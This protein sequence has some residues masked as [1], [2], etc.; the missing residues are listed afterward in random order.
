[1]GGPGQQRDRV[2]VTRALPG[3][4]LAATLALAGCTLSS[5]ATGNPSAL[6]DQASAGTQDP[7]NGQDESPRR[8]SSPALE[9]LDRLPV[10]SRAGSAG[11]YRRSE[12]GQSWVDTDGNGCNQRDDVLLRDA[13]PDRELVV[14]T[15]G[16][17]DHDVLAGTWLDPYT[18][19]ELTFT[20]LKDQAQ[21]QAIQIDHVVSLSDAWASGAW[22]WTPLERIGFANDL[23]NL[24]AV[25][26][27]TNQAKS[28]RGPPDWLPEVDRCRYVEHYVQVK[29]AY[30]LGVSGDAIAGLRRLL[31]QCA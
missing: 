2:R 3:L 12:F 21:A 14:V 20:D 19:R 9:A 5:S 1:M 28:D 18:G 24:L 23:D 27:P 22:E 30:G 10:I 29:D 16:S 4:L 13:L 26:G 11:G 8:A 15:Q 17:C 6:P 25:D 31:Q 7:A